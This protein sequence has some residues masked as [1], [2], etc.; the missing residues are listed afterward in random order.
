[1]KQHISYPSI[2]SLRILCST[3][4]HHAEYEGKDETGEVIYNPDLPKPILTFNGTTKL[5]GS[6]LS[7]CFSNEDSLWC[8]SRE[9]IITTEDDHHGFCKFVEERKS[10]FIELLANTLKRIL[11]DDE[12]VTIFGE[13]VGKGIQKGTAINN[14][15]KSF[16]IFGAKVTRGEEHEW[17]PIT[18]IS[19]IDK[20]IYN[21]PAFKNYSV[22]ID[23]NNP[24][25][26][27]EDL[28]KLTDEVETE[29]P[30]AKVFG[31]SGI[32]EGIVWTTKYKNWT[33]RF[34]SKGTKH[35]ISKVKTPNTV[36]VEKVN[37]VNEFVNYAVTENRFE[38]G[39]D[40]VFGTETP[41]IQKMGELMKW[42]VQDIEKE[43]SDVLIENNLTMKDVN[44]AISTEV[45]K[46]F[47]ELLD[48]LVFG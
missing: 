29:C 20:R 5:H 38:Q 42:V 14:L 32:G 1:M 8:Q 21:L 35:K 24:G 25:S 15:E 48:K 37:S 13:W 3:V 23:F 2:D 19:N 9:V 18:N 40:K 12:I 43:E 31:F 11:Q 27:V 33:Y 16:F 30:V 10:V 45:R 46:R 36:D 7:V 47:Q 44:K 39:L 17:L 4:K 26:S 41:V 6:N 34:K 28:D 22:T